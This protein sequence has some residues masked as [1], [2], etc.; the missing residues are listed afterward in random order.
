MTIGAATYGAS[1]R[2]GR[3]ENYYKDYSDDG[4]AMKMT[5]IVSRLDCVKK[6]MNSFWQQEYILYPPIMSHNSDKIE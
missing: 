3:K 1:N 4:M 6:I 2:D 5:P